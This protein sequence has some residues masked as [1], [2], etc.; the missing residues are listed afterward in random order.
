MSTRFRKFLPLALALVALGMIAAACG[1]EAPAGDCL[2]P[3][4]GKLVAADCV[5]P[6]GATAEPTPTPSG[7][8][9]GGVDPG[10][11]LVRTYG[12]SACHSIDGTSATGQVGPNLTHVGANGADFVRQ[13]IIDPGAVIA[14]G[15][16][17]G[18]MPKTFGTAIP[19]ADLDSLVEYLS[20][21]K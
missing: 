8:G 3:E 6:P 11:A 5:V 20:G 19:A 18:I 9:N 17:D 21:L 2:T 12:C 1:A 15:F 14:D 4:D 7:N 16:T 10:F 13:S